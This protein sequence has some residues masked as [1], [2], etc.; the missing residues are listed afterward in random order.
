[1]SSLGEAQGE[2][3]E[4]V[5]GG[6]SVGCGLPPSV[7]GIERSSQFVCEVPDLISKILLS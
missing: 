6:W 7:K 2:L 5:C 1:M 4:R 3:I